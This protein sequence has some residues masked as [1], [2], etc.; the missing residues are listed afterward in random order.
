MAA[1]DRYV[2]EFWRVLFTNISVESLR[3]LALL[4]LPSSICSWQ[5]FDDTYCC[6]GTFKVNDNVE[7]GF[8]T[9]GYASMVNTI[10]FVFYAIHCNDEETSM[11]RGQ[12]IGLVNEKTNI[13]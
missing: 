6:N 1:R 11:L 5:G 8:T 12:G 2:Y 7:V 3:R 13:N 9:M 4:H 10:L